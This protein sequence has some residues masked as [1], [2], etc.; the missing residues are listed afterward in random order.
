MAKTLKEIAE[1]ADVSVGTVDRVIH[2][3]GEVAEDTKQKIKKIL[4]KVDYSPNLIAKTL[5]SKEV[6]TFGVL[7]PKL[8]QDSNYWKLPAQ[9]IKYAADELDR[10]KIN[11]SNYYY[12]KY[13]ESSFQEQCENILSDLSSLDGLLIAPNLS[14]PAENF[15]QKL[16]DDFPFVIFDSDISTDKKLSFIGQDPFQ[17]G[18]L[19]GKLMN[20]LINNTGHI[21]IVRILPEDYHLDTRIQGFFSYY[22][23]ITNVEL[24]T[25][26]ADL[27]SSK[28]IVAKITKKIVENNKVIKGLFVPNAHTHEVAEYIANNCYDRKIF[29][30]G[31]DMIQPNIKYLKDGVIDFLLNQR[32]INQGY[33]GINTL[34]RNILLEESIVDEIDI[35]TDIITQENIDN[36]QRYIDI[37][38]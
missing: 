1:M 27:H 23:N 5:S 15:V 17:S 31:Y 11:I 18:K 26:Q 29:L 38:N 2:D 24:E 16:P 10:Y 4:E 34:F 32:P 35:P 36:Y 7:M 22:K 21:G 37:M 33:L 25:H 9:G 30:I 19:A 13:S 6:T 28:D 8:S 3:R 14:K 20:L 12:D